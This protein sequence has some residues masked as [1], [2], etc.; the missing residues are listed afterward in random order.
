MKEGAGKEGLR[1]VCVVAR[2]FADGLAGVGVGTV[3]LGR[4]ERDAAEVMAE[5]GTREVQR[6][7]GVFER[8]VEDLR[9]LRHGERELVVEEGDL[10]GVGVS[11]NLWARLTIGGVPTT[12]IAVHFLARPDDTSRKDRREAQA[13]VIRRLA[14]REL[15][16]GRAVAVVGDF[17]DFDDATLDRNGSRPITDVM[18][19]IKSAGPSPTDD[20]TNV[21]A[22]VPQSERFTAFWDRDRDDRVE[23]G[24]L[25]AIDHILLSPALYRRVRE[26]RFVH[27]HDPR[28]V[29]DHFPIVVT[30]AE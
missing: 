22:D 4:G 19:R 21:L 2:V 14:E 18:A 30:L 25:S 23:E 5:R 15:A 1:A 17:N 3:T 29:S 27:A 28:R 10:A 13:E 11:K 12:I 26:V 16:A 9:D 24:E 20:L 6:L 7:G 8:V